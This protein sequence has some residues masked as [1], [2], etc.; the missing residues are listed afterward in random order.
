MRQLWPIFVLA[1]LCCGATTAPSPSLQWLDSLDAGYMRSQQTQQPILVVIGDDSIPASRRLWQQ[2]QNAPAATG[3]SNTTLVRLTSASA[4]PAIRSLGVVDLPALRKLTPLGQVF[5][6]HD[7]ACSDV[8]LSKFLDQAAAA[9]TGTESVD[10]LLKQLDSRNAPEREAAVRGL[11]SHLESMPSVI[12]ALSDQSLT[13]RLSAVELL[14]RWGAP[15]SGIDPWNADSLTDARRTAI[16]N[17]AKVR[18]T[19]QSSTRSSETSATS[20]ELDR[21]CTAPSEPEA[22]AVRERLIINGESLI[23]AIV[24]RLERNPPEPARQRLLALRYRLVAANQLA[25]DWSGGF[26]RLASSDA[27]VRHAAIA[28]LAER[29]KPEDH[30][31]LRELFTDADP[32][33]REQSLK[34]LRDVGGAE[35]DK[36]LVALLADPSSEVRA[37]VLTTLYEKPNDA[38]A[39]DLV[40][41][42][43]R[44]H[45]TDLL[46]HA[47][48][49]L[50]VTNGDATTECLRSLLHHSEWR[51]RGEAAES[52]RE[53]L[54]SDNSMNEAQKAATY[55]ALEKCLDDP[56]GYVVN[57]AA[58]ALIK[59]NLA[60]AGSHLLDAV[61]RRPE[62]AHD[63][64]RALGQENQ[65]DP[66]MKKKII[67]LATTGP[68]AVR[69]E[70]I[71][72]AAA[73]APDSCGKIISAALSDS[74]AT[75]RHAAANA[76]LVV[77]DHLFPSS[78]TVTHSSFLGLGPDST[79]S[80]DRAKWVEDFRQGKGQPAWFTKSKANFITLLDQPETRAAAAVA[81]CAAGEDGRA[82]ATFEG[83]MGD[84]GSRKTLCKALV[85]LPFDKKIDLYNRLIAKSPSAEYETILE[86]F[87]AVPDVRLGPPLWKLLGNDAPATLLSPVYTALLKAYLDASEYNVEQAPLE[88]RAA[89]LKDCKDKATNGTDLQRT[90]AMAMILAIS[91]EQAIPIARANYESPQSSEWLR[92]D[93]LQILLLS[94]VE[95]D[96]TKTAVA[97]LSSRPMRKVAIPFLAAGSDEI[98]E[99]RGEL[100]LYVRYTSTSRRAEAVTIDAPA[101]LEVGPL[102]EAY[103]DAGDN[104]DLAAYTGYLLTLVNDRTGYPALLARARANRFSTPWD[105][106]AYRAI[107][108]LND[109][110][111]MPYLTDL[112]HHYKEQSYQMPEFYWT[113]RLMTGDKILKLRKTIRDEVGMEQLQRY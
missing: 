40:A 104:P 101:G 74:D 88:N 57:R 99:V 98:R 26:D 73:M 8:E 4:A 79:E 3:L 82:E 25:A 20:A 102:L 31:L 90:A 5:A 81:L 28:D 103:H 35:T 50:Q 72:A 108:K 95:D 12:A 43:G 6:S 85:W 39:A 58:W 62:L 15:V 13:C 24:Q 112:Y 100:S 44:E 71:P 69:S 64:F 18:S 11:E 66:L 49:V 22:R 46:V 54:S 59:S 92:L 110:E 1:I 77:L 63:V 32:F 91:N 17:W 65:A 75:V 76:T 105:R 68:A 70:A 61:Q 33:V 53:K 47:V 107:A 84:L 41:Y 80:I 38:L 51:V 60:S 16:A 109:S 96:A 7:G 45:E 30:R 21:L 93:S 106:L 29:A 10:S 27:T 83:L 113:I 78:G 56:D 94:Q 2:L 97:A 14:Q 52:L 86:N 55:V 19:T 48:H 34:M 37:A 67:D 23:P 36:T 9:A 89:A 87:T 111:Q 42:V